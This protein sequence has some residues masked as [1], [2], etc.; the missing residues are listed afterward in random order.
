M[1]RRQHVRTGPASVDRLI[2]RADHRFAVDVETRIEHGADAP[3][4]GLV[5]Q[6]GELAGIVGNQLRTAGAV[7]A[8]TPA[9]IS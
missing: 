5:Q 8:I 7:D 3:P 2:R 9:D 6:L 1:G 4:Q